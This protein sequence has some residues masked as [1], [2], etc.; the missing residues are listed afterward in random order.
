MPKLKLLFISLVLFSLFGCTQLPQSNVGS[1]RIDITGLPANTAAD[2][3]LSGPGYSKKIT[4]S[5]TIEG[6]KPNKYYISAQPLSTN[7]LKYEAKVSETSINVEAGQT[8]MVNVRY[9]SKKLYQI[10]LVVTGPGRVKSSDGK[11]SCTS[12]GA[13]CSYA[14]DEGSE[15]TLRAEPSSGAKFISWNNDK[16]NTE[17]SFSLVADSEQTVT[18]KFLKTPKPDITDPVPS[19]IKIVSKLNETSLTSFSFENKGV[20]KLIFSIEED[21]DWLE[22]KTLNGKLASGKKQTINLEASCSDTAENLSTEVKIKSNDPDEELKVVKISLECKAEPKKY[23]LKITLDGSGK[24]TSNDGNIDCSAKKTDKCSFSYQENHKVVLTASPEADFEFVA[25]SGASK[26]DKASI[27]I[28]MDA[29]KDLAAKFI[30]YLSPAKISAPSPAKLLINAEVNQSGQASFSFSNLGGKDLKYTISDSFDWLSQSPEFG[31]LKGSKKQDIL[32]SASCPANA[33]IYT[34]TIKISSNDEK[35]PVITVLLNLD[36]SNIT[37]QKQ[38][39]N[40][41]VKGPGTVTTADGHINCNSSG[42]Q[43]NYNYPTASKIELTATEDAQAVFDGWSQDS[44]SSEKI[45]NIT[46]DQAHNLTANFNAAET[47]TLTVAVSGPGAITTVDGNIN[48]SASSNQCSFDYDLN[49]NVSLVASPETDME[50]KSWS[51]DCS[52]NSTCSLSMTKDMNVSAL[53]GAPSA[54]GNYK[55]DFVLLGSAADADKKVVF[56]EAATNWQKVIVSQLSSENVNL[57]ANGACGYGEDA[58]SQTVDGL[59]IVASIVAIDG[60]GGI[61]GQAGPRFIR[62]NGLPV[63]GCMQFDEADIAAMVDNGTFN[64]VIMHEMGH[65]LGVGTLWKYKN[66]MNDYQPT[67]ACQSASASFT[68]K[69]S[70]IGANALTEFTSLGGTGNIPVE[71]EYGPGTRCGHWDEAKFGNELMTGFVAQGTMPL[72][73]MTAASLKD[74]GYSVDMNAADSYSIPAIRTSSINGFELKEQLIY[75]A[76]KLNPY[77]RMIKLK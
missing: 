51:G 7:S 37:A 19:E 25:W 52:G 53:F 47:R 3:L 38:L 5:S 4:G 68:T 41:T 20:D 50:L 74:L 44:N 43:C 18:A 23:E 17:T 15:V 12:S 55:I 30:K 63:V 14:Y 32:V 73:R 16:E 57:E 36:C 59:L 9:S 54:S 22:S 71:D 75:P 10:K 58:I 8:A 60:K 76:Y 31:T 6:L 34:D 61:L 45:I 11:I 67:D 26:E 48:C 35:N 24:V 65:V 77:G 46:M 29:N 21:V 64:G 27:E 2:I 33:G 40:L 72:S 69:P 56:E 1:V 66:L 28:T 39:L 42:G 13:R 49:A 62:D 70:F